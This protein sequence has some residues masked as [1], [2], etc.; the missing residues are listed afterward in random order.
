MK[1]I[2]CGQ[3]FKQ[4]AYNKTNECDDCVDSILFNDIDQEME[5]EI[6]LLKNPNGKT[7]SQ[8]TYDWDD[9]HGF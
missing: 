8:I 2:T 4:S 9:S 7:Q 3:Y 6:N 5:V 1:C